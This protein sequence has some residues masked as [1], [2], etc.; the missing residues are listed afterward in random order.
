M[1]S[2]VSTRKAIYFL[3]KYDWAGVEVVE[4]HDNVYD[5]L[6]CCDCGEVEPMGERRIQD[7]QQQKTLCSR[8]SA[9]F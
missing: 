8:R 2:L 6:K 1:V 9:I 3:G 4:D 7:L 5:K